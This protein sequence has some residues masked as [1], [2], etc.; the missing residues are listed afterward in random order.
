MTPTIQ[1]PRVLI[2]DDKPANLD[3]LEAMLAPLDCALVRAVSA[4]QALLALVRDDFAAIVLDIR[5]PGMSGI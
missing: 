4:D 5:M 3:V 1:L 2:V